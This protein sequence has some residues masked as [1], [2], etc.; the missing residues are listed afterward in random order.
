MPASVFASNIRDYGWRTEEVRW[1][2]EAWCAK[3]GLGTALTWQVCLCAQEPINQLHTGH[4]RIN[5]WCV[6]MLL[7]AKSAHKNTVCLHELL[8]TQNSAVQWWGRLTFSHLQMQTRWKLYCNATFFAIILQK[9]QL[10]CKKWRHWCWQNVKRSKYITRVHTPH[11]FPPYLM[12][13]TV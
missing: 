12:P 2:R 9:M 7:R 8:N 5:I 4:L 1:G 13:T 6:H 3:K 11:W 10:Y